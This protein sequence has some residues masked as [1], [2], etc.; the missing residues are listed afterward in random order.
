MAVIA[1]KAKNLKKFMDTP[2]TKESLMKAGM[3]KFKSQKK[4]V[5]S[6]MSS[7]GAL[8]KAEVGEKQHTGKMVKKGKVLSYKDY[9]QLGNP[10]DYSKKKTNKDDKYMRSLGRDGQ[11]ALKARRVKKG[12]YDEFGR[13]K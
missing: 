9:P 6:K 3:P 5:L 2:V 10:K 11:I 7:N 13:N 1:K 8:K 12:K 4:K